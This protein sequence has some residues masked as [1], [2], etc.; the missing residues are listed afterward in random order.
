MNML[1]Q[2]PRA[3]CSLQCE[4]GRESGR[5]AFGG[6][7]AGLGAGPA[8]GASMNTGCGRGAA[9]ASGMA[10][11]AGATKAAA[12]TT[13]RANDAQGANEGPVGAR[14]PG[15]WQ[16][17]AASQATRAVP[18][19]AAIQSDKSRAAKNVRTLAWYLARS[20]RL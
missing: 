4:R 1:K 10:A 13:C 14:C 12:G 16:C 5:Q 3:E 9:A 11:G 18:A 20:A 6:G 19:G 8:R 17:G 2:T 15:Q 7:T